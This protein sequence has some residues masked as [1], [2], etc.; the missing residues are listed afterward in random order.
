MDRLGE[1]AGLSGGGSFDFAVDSHRR[2]PV[3]I[4]AW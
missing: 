2:L 4:R 3:L 1:V